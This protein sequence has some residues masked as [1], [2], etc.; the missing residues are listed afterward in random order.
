[1]YC[2][3][4][5]RSYAVGGNT[6]KVTKASLKP[7]LKRWEGM[8]KYIEHTT[9]L[10]DIV[11]S[12]GDSYSLTPEQVY[13]IGERLISIPHIRHFRFASKGFAVCPG[14]II[15]PYDYWA[16][17]LI[18]ISKLGRRYGKAVAL[19]TH[20]NHLNEITWV[21]RRAS[22][23]LFE[24]GVTIRNQSVLLRGVNDNLQTMSSLIQNLADMNIQPVS[25][26]RKH[27]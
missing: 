11:V 16:K 9:S 6:N 19:H 2:R 4:C 12:G 3:F 15:D 5:T 7:T 21:T 13:T 23:Y 10:R 25:Q 27:W 22:Q 8:F 1:V 14:R 18:E 17:S 26:V 20:I 24:E